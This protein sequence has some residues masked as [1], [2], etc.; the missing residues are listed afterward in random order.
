[1]S[2]EALT[3]E[4]AREAEHDLVVL[5]DDAVAGGASVGF[6]PP[7]D[8]VVARA[9]W[10]DTIAAVAAGRRVLLLA[11][12]GDAAVGTGQLGFPAMP[13]GRHRAEVMKL[14]VLRS[15]RRRGI[16]RA[17]MLAL[18]DEARRRGRTTLVLD[19]RQG[20]VS[21]RLYASLGWRLAGIIPAYAESADGRL[22][23]T[24]VYYKRLDV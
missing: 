23:A 14:M 18:E 5:L 4:R 1:M 8:P 20:D 11:R 7:L 9:Y 22:D 16:G 24:A 17:L 21:E 2:I 10:R 12:E 15:A 6:L 13:N 3:P 19:T